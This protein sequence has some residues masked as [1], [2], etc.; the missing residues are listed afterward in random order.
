MSVPKSSSPNRDSTIK[1]KNIRTIDL[2]CGAGGLTYGLHMAGLNVVAG[3][4]IDSDCRYAYEV[5]NPKSKFIE[6]DINSLNPKEINKFYSSDAYKVLVGCAPCQ[7]FSKYTRANKE[8]KDQKW[9]LV[10][11]FANLITAI[12]PDVISMENVPELANHKVYAEF[13]TKLQKA[14]YFVSDSIVF[15]PAYGIPQQRERLV[16]FASRFGPINIIPPLYK[17][18][19]YPT[20]KSAIGNL[21][22]LSAGDE[23]LSDRFHKSSNLSSLNLKRIKLSNPGGSWRDWPIDLRAKCHQSESGATY[24]SVYGRMEWSKPSPTIT[25]QYFGFG[26]GRFGH[27]EQDRA[28]SLREGAILQSFPN[29]Y[30]LTAP[31]K[32]VCFATVGKM[33]GNAVPPKLGEAV[34]KTILNH[35]RDH[36][37]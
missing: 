8:S 29:N 33:I 21:E 31:E 32:K 7:S 13:V 3:Y 6:Q 28:I 1:Y 17:P 9:A 19:N 23:S 11:T 2:F 4:D 26:S 35:L 34:G 12:M 14:N 20:V 15:C 36:D 37:S 25:T 27:P 10:G 30:V 24:P 16:L 18:E 5:N 22:H